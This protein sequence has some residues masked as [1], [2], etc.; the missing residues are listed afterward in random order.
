MLKGATPADEPT[1][2]LSLTLPPGT[3]G[4]QRHPWTNITIHGLLFS[5][6]VP[7]RPLIAQPLYYRK[8]SQSL[9][10]SDRASHIMV[11]RHD[12]HRD[13]PHFFKATTSVGLLLLSDSPSL[14]HSL[15]MSLTHVFDSEESSEVLSSCKSSENLEVA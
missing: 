6:G 12:D 9:P 3:K 11:H 7:L 14:T 2:Y 1:S 15:S 13:M 8:I 4:P 10:A 5:T